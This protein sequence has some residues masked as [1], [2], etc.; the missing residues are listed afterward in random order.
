MDIF[1]SFI[2]LSQSEKLTRLA[3]V[4]LHFILKWS[5]IAQINNVIN[6]DS[7]KLIREQNHRTT[8]AMI[9]CAVNPYKFW[10]LRLFLAKM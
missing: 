2:A 10:C 8:F 5:R 4:S 6:N 3:V 7:G 9:A 1:P